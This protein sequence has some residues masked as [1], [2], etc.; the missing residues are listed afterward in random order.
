M[1]IDQHRAHL[2]ILYDRYLAQLTAS[3]GVTQGL[4]FPDIVHLS[5]S[6]AATLDAIQPDLHALGLEVN[7]L[8]GDSVA[9]HGLPAGL[10]G[11]DPQR[12]L[13]DLLASVAERG[14]LDSEAIHG[15]LAL[16]L[17]R[18]AAIPA[19]QVLSNIEMQDLVEQL[20][21]TATP[22]ITPDGH[23][24]SAILP[25]ETIDKLFK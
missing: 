13:L 5:A 4:L 16:T 1:F 12:L 3:N 19:G 6:D 15:R 8:G 21:A 7:S 20:Q 14:S 10:E 22:S 25:Q 24:V 23:P 18:A 2:R 17:A 11:V 9:I